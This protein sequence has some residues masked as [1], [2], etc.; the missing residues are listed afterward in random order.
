MKKKNHIAVLITCFNRKENTVRCIQ[1]LLLLK[2]DVDIYLVDDKSTD[3]T[4]EEIKLLFPNICLIQGNG[5]LFW[6]RG[7]HL[8]WEHASKEHYDYYL[9]L[10]DDVVLYK[11]CFEELFECDK[12]TGGNSIISG[13]IESEEKNEILY[14]GTDCKNQLIIPNGKMN[15]ITNMNGNVVLV[16]KLVHKLIGN[17]DPYYHHD[18]GDVDYCLMALKKGI[19]VYTTRI[20]IASCNKNDLF[21]AR[22]NNSTLIK[23]IKK[24]YSP[25]GA[26]PRIIFYF[27]KKHHNVFFASIYFVFQHFLNIIPDILNEKIFK[28]KYQ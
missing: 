6:N 24:L 20:P 5:N 27:H 11:N 3:G 14:G 17:L 10:N 18:L 4:S 13:I 16:P 15:T 28:N 7:M 12:L 9:W 19:C 25:L 21:R 26:N 22:L 8:A 23:R 2:N 1:K